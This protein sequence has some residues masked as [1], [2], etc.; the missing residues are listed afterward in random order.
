MNQRAQV[1]VV[2]IGAAVVGFACGNIASPDVHD[3]LLFAVGAT[4]FAAIAMGLVSLFSPAGTSVMADTPPRKL[5]GLRVAFVGF[6]I[7]LTGFVVGVLVWPR[8]GFLLVLFGVMTGFL[9]II[10][11]FVRAFSK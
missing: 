3:Q 7:A 11:H 10:I 2:L 5:L 4:T 8:A 9:G 6:C 1:L